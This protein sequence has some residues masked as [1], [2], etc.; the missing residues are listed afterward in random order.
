MFNEINKSID[1]AISSG[2]QYADARIL[3][4]KSRDISSK[5]GELEDFSNS[6]NMGLGIRALVGSSWGFYATYDLSDESLKEAGKK[7]YLIAKASSKVPGKDFPL[8]DVPIVKDEYVTPH[9]QNP[10]K[11]STTD[12]IDLICLLYTSPSPRDPT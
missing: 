7:A 11:V 2:A 10:F 4:S 1:A 8:A 12:Q 3:I 6:E 5:D 9:E